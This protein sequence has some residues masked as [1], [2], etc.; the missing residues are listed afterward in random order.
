MG[1]DGVD[2]GNHL[3]IGVFGYTDDVTIISTRPVIMTQRVTVVQM[4]HVVRGG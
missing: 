1:D 2:V 3:R 4:G